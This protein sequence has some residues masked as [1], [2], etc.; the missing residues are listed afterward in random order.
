MSFIGPRPAL[1]YHPWTIDKYDEEQRR[2][3]DVLPGITGWAQVHGRKEVPWPE[4][5]KLNV[6]YVAKSRFGMDM[7]I[8]FSTIFKVL[9]NANNNNISKTN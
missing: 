7:K 1:T 2:M 8:C 9:T 3:F 4:R 5:I 6:E